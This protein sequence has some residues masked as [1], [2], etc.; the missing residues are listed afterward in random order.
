MTR[1]R[2][3]TSASPAAAAP[4][5]TASTGS[6]RSWARATPAS[7]RIRPIC[8]LRSPRSKRR[9]MSPGP[10]ASARSRS[11]ISIGLPGD[12]P[13]IDTNLQAGRDHHGDRTAGAGLCG[14]L[15]LSEDPRPPVLCVR[16]CVGC[17]RARARGRP[18]KEA[19]LALGGVA[20][21]PWREPEAEAALRGQAADEAAFAQAA[22]IAA[23]RRQ[24]LRAQCLQDRSRAPRASFAR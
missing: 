9:F 23:A 2:R 7:R 12:T 19:R 6:T 20:H 14:Q 24:G 22:D 17:G 1:R 5:S 18:I 10:A 16:A 15:Q 4:P 13:H 3:A 11:P 21:K 8:A